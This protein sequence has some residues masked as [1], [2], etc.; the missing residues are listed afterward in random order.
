MKINEI[1]TVNNIGVEG[2]IMLSET[3][4]TN[5]TLTQ[6]DLSS[7]KNVNDMIDITEDKRKFEQVIILE[8]KELEC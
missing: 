4:K 5:T 3:L 8:M 6:L 7:D 2:A 1:W